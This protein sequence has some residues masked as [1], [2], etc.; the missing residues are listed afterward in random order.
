M[1]AIMS[2]L[3]KYAPKLY[4]CTVATPDKHTTWKIK[5]DLPSY[6]STDKLVLDTPATKTLPI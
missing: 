3:N 2:N 5:R 6:S 4:T 1:F